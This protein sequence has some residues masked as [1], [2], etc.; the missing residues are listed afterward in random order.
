[1]SSALSKMNASENR[2]RSS[3][4]PL[5][6]TAMATFRC[7]TRQDF[8]QAIQKTR[9]SRRAKSFAVGERDV[10]LLDEPQRKRRVNEH[11]RV[12][13]GLEID[14]ADHEDAEDDDEAIAPHLGG[15]LLDAMDRMEI[16]PELRAITTWLDD[17]R[18][19]HN[20]PLR[21]S[22]VDLSNGVALLDALYVVDGSVFEEVEYGDG[23]GIVRRYVERNLDEDGMAAARNVRVL[24]QALGRFNWRDKDDGGR[25]LESLDFAMVDTWGLAGFVVL[26]AYLCERS[27][28]FVEQMVGYEEWVVKSLEDVMWRG[29]QA[30]GARDRPGRDESVGGVSASE[31]GSSLMSEEESYWKRRALE[32]EKMLRGERKKREEMEKMAQD[33]E[34][35]ADAWEKACKGFER[36][37]SK[38]K[39]EMLQSRGKRKVLKESNGEESVATVGR[40]VTQLRADNARLRRRV[41]ELEKRAE[42]REKEMSR[43]LRDN[44]RRG[45]GVGI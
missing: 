14:L 2:S 42:L 25:A 9:A 13:Q 30:L 24:R 35:K 12:G 36:S 31:E 3:V 21:I 44:R 17:L 29:L 27:D 45:K 20:F 16:T 8:F 26:A 43:V 18:T 15:K 28:E 38:M 41:A 7:P 37:I 23:G 4:G 5:S 40:T 10:S 33:L 11:R 34:S 19:R 39:G 1:M 32:A 22:D 6:S